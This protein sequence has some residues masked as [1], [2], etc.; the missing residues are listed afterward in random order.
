MN[1]ANAAL[2]TVPGVETE[3]EAAAP[4]ILAT[5]EG[6]SL[7]LS[8]RYAAELVDAVKRLPLAE[9]DGESKTWTVAVCQQTFDALR[10]MYY[11]RLVTP[12]PDELLAEGETLETVK[13]AVLRPGSAR[14]PYIVVLSL[15]DDRVFAQLK[16]VP[17]AQWE[18]KA[19]GLSYPPAA[20]AALAE[21][22]DRGLIDDADGLLRPADVTI[23]FDTRIGRFVVRGDK[24]AQP[25]FDHHFPDRDVYAAWIGKG[26][27][28]AFA[29]ELTE[30]IYR[31]ELARVG[32][33]I[34]PERMREALFAY[35]QRDVAVAIERSGFAFLSS[36]GVGKCL[37][38]DAL[39][40]TQEGCVRLDTLWTSLARGVVPSPDGVGEWATPAEE[41]WVRSVDGTGKI[42]PARASRLYRQRVRED[43]RRIT[44]SDG[45]SVTITAAHRLLTEDRGWDATI[46]PGDRVA[47][48]TRAPAG[49][50]TT[51]P[52]LAEVLA[53]Q[54]GEGYEAAPDALTQQ[55]E[56][57]LKGRQIVEELA[58][59]YR[60]VAATHDLDVTSLSVREVRGRTTTRLRI[61]IRGYASFLQG[62]GYT[63]GHRSAEKS[64]PRAIQSAEAGTQRAFLRAYLAAEAHVNLPG[65]H[66]EV[67][68]A[69][70]LLMEQLRQMLRTFGV[71]LR[72]TVKFK[73]ATNGTGTLR[74]Y[75]VGLISGDSVERL[76][77]GVGIADRRKQQHLRDI[78]A[79]AGGSGNFETWS[80]ETLR[81][82]HAELRVP[83]GRLGLHSSAVV[84]G[85]R[86]TRRTLSRAATGMAELADGTVAAALQARIDAGGTGSR[87]IGVQRTEALLAGLDRTR[88]LDFAEAV[89]GEAEQDLLFLEVRAVETIPHA[90]YVYDLEVPVHHNFVAN[91]VVCHNTAS[92]LGTAME[93]LNR[94]H[95]QRVVV[96]A[97]AALRSQWAAE[98]VR[99]CEISHSDVVVVDGTKAKRERAYL[100][101]L[102]ATFVILHYDVL[103]R[104]LELIRPLVDGQLLVLDE[105]HRI[106][107]YTSQRSKAARELGRVAAR[108][109]AMTGTPVENHP[110]EWFQL[111]GNFVAP[112]T[113]GAPQDFLNRYM[114]P[115]RFGGYEGA[116]NLVELRERTRVHYQRFTKADVAEHLPP[117]RVQ[118][119]VLDVD[120]AY[121]K[122]LR[123]AHRDARDQIARDRVTKL[124][125]RTGGLLDGEEL[126]EAEAGAEMT[127]V[128][129]LRALCSSPRLLEASDSAAAEALRKAG[130]V[131]PD[132]DGP[133][134]D[135]LR[136]IA[137]DLQ[138]VS[139]RR[140][141]AAPAGH[142]PTPNEVTG[143]R[144]VV[145]TYS[146][147]MADLIVE[148]LSADGVKCVSYTGSTKRTDRDAAVAAF[149]DPSSD[150]T[151]FVATDAAAEGLNLGRCCNLLVNFDV[152]WN[153]ST[154]IQR[155]NRIHRVD[156]TAPH[157]LVMNFT[158]AG[159]LEAGILKL[160][161]RKVELADTILGERGGAE[162]TVGR[163]TSLAS[164]LAEAFEE[165]DG[166][167]LP[168]PAP[169]PEPSDGTGASERD[170]QDEPG[171]Q[172]VALPSGDDDERA[173]LWQPPVGGELEFG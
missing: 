75:T 84:A 47:V 82:A 5:R 23:M 29:D 17:G 149:T 117:L 2:R 144:L 173:R 92:A 145:F 68:S 133:K 107:G 118:N 63:Y 141:A 143:E 72:T 6:G 58:A 32:D 116:R 158:L 121:A 160:L 155:G 52:L 146:R 123:T 81:A 168:E 110:A 30:E 114:Y 50:A 28:V 164:L 125:A 9:F 93:N 1:A 100:A 22:A 67:S 42:R 109:I 147:K 120:P 24:R 71:I 33:G 150:V 65:R 94:G 46:R 101:G 112:G 35:Q 151:A 137:R 103:K 126:D 105:A 115:G 70:P 165:L 142:V 91:G 27:D 163:R 78:A 139:D 13:P 7:R 95:V 86:L 97:P 55:V 122:V 129:M 3:H 21:L 40:W 132:E 156:G 66:V 73:R 85:R 31:G 106:K 11:N 134:L 12:Y 90:G 166:R 26:H 167:P 36:P 80:N 74:P 39:V 25:V 38:G 43:L 161:E 60:T 8:F 15:R 37:T 89:R 59:K 170:G 53:W 18:K 87:N 162:K 98:T 61:G 48:P 34:Q 127:A 135:E 88:A 49:N 96:V 54:I 159:T 64:I 16:A 4:P 113:L 76:Y 153:P 62:L 152:P 57:S 157:Y 130:I 172:V 41:L 69:S 119:V 131:P 44:L 108:R 148:R 14:R 171:G 104:D 140:R 124:T 154:L 169:E 111:I 128:G 102:D 77:A 10:R 136:Q 79:S 99:F 19:R 83:P 20:T 45:S 51:D 56:I 138:S